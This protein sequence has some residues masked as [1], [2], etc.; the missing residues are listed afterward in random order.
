M[1][2]RDP[3]YRPYRFALWILYFAAIVVA[4]A[5]VVSSIVRDLRGPPV[6]AAGDVPTRAALRVC[7]TDLE[8]LAREQD[9]RLWRLASDASPGDAVARWNAW[10]ADWEI[11]MRDLSARC[12]LDHADPASPD[13]ATIEEIARARNAVMELHAGYARLVN[14]FADDQADLARGAQ[15]ALEAAHGAVNRPRD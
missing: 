3:R 10:S 5:V 15:R 11:R 9:E 2:P 7:L 13:R 4:S 1:A 6:P 12:A 14:R 8:R